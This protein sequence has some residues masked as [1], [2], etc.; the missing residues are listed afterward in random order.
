MPAAGPAHG[1]GAG[2]GA[3][4]GRRGLEGLRGGRQRWWREAVKAGIPWQRLGGGWGPGHGTGRALGS[5]QGLAGD[6]TLTPAAPGPVPLPAAGGRCRGPG[7]RH[8][9]RRC[10]A[11]AAAG[12]EGRGAHGGQ[13][14]P[15]G[16][17]RGRSGGMPPP[18]DPAGLATLPTLPPG[19]P[20]T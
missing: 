9:R 15:C 8:W 10:G 20:G 13:R 17:E 3:R 11:P 4:G 7:Q 16:G 12:A 18:P 1:L 2:A 5:S 19:L 6:G 14:C